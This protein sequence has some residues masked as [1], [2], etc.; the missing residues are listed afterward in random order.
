MGTTIRY[1][2]QEPPEEQP[3]FDFSHFV[4]PV[5]EATQKRVLAVNNSEAKHLWY[6]CETFGDRFRGAIDCGANIG[7][8]T[9]VLAM[10]YKDV[11]AFEPWPEL[12]EML[13]TNSAHFPSSNVR[14]SSK[15]VGA[16]DY[17]GLMYSSHK[18]RRDAHLSEAPKGE[19]GLEKSVEVVSL[20][21]TIPIDQPIDIIK[22]DVEGTE[23]DVLKGAERII[24]QWEPLIYIEIKSNVWQE[25]EDYLTK[26]GYSQLAS[27]THN[28]LFGAN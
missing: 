8:M 12:F 11:W 16:S 15:A 5:H 3:V 25:H 10:L 19:K 18:S 20:D 14:L 7:S 24:Q 2:E 22:I 13:E 6:A 4:M 26:I 9:Y 23:I 21:N 27:H 28:Y 1:T 17:H